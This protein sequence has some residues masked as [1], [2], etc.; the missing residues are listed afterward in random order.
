MVLADSPE[1]QQQF[2]A[3]LSQTL[4]GLAQNAEG[5]QVFVLSFES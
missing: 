2:A 5:L 1:A 3:T 4:A